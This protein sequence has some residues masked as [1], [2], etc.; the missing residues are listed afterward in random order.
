[1]SSSATDLFARPAHNPSFFEVSA[2]APA[3]NPVLDF[4]VPVNLHYPK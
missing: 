2:A 1:M 3:R 4:C